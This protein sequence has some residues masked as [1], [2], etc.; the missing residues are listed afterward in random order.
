M[1][2]AIVAHPTTARLAPSERHFP[3]G[4]EREPPGS[5]AEQGFAGES[6]PLAW[7]AGQGVRLAHALEAMIAQNTLVCSLFLFSI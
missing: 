1:K 6:T 2:A 3:R 5:S 7:D 4:R